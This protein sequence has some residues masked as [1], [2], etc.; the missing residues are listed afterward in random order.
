MW[1]LWKWH[2]DPSIIQR[3]KYKCLLW[4][5]LSTFEYFYMFWDI[6]RDENDFLESNH[7]YHF[8]GLP[9][10]SWQINI[11]S[12]LCVTQMISTRPYVE[13]ITVAWE[14]R[15]PFN[16]CYYCLLI[17]CNCRGLLWIYKPVDCFRICFYFNRCLIKC[18]LQFFWYQSI[19]AKKILLI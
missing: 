19:Y 15:K 1:W 7:G 8:F 10:E 13:K 2:F 14:K 4:I 18:A 16:I 6:C 3:T 5:Y 9:H 17:E 12:Y 11:I